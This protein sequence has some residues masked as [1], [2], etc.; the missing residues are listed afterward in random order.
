MGNCCAESAGNTFVFCF[1]IFGGELLSVLGNTQPDQFIF[2]I[3]ALVS[4]SM[5]GFTVVDL[6][7]KARLQS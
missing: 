2:L 4:P 6:R 3:P 5:M 7:I 1:I